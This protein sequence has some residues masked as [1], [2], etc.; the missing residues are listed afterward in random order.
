MMKTQRCFW[1]LWSALLI[2][3]ILGSSAE[4]KILK[5]KD[6]TGKVFFTDDISKVPAQYRTDEHKKKLKRKFSPKGRA[7]SKS[8]GV[9]EGKETS[10]EDV[11]PPES[12]GGQLKISDDAGEEKS[13]KKKPPIP[14]EGLIMETKAFLE[15]DVKAMDKLV[16]VFPSMNEKNGK[17]LALPLKKTVGKRME[18]AA[19]IDQAEAP[20]LQPIADFLLDSAKKDEKFEVGG[21]DYL[22][23]IQQLHVRVKSE[24]SRKKLYLKDLEDKLKKEE[25]TEEK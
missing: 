16:S 23:R 25:D 10:I 1:I 22:E 14:H 12:G 5:W 20:G 2:F 9:A 13:K 17:Y 24:L 3:G 11:A 8:S 4:A 15:Q 18:I 21:E 19:K 7:S 6:D